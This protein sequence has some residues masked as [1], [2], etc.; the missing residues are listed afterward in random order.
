M[1]GSMDGSSDAYATIVS[2]SR[3]AETIEINGKYAIS[4]D[5]RGR[6]RSCIS[7][8]MKTSKLTILAKQ[9]SDS[10][11]LTLVYLSFPIDL[12][13]RFNKVQLETV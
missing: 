1:N 5:E 10:S 9:G 6:L 11:P 4:W 2:Q 3:K 12:S 8:R 7:P 13:N